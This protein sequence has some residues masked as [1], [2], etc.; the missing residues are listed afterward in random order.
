VTS[1]STTFFLGWIILAI[2]ILAGILVVLNVVGNLLRQVVRKNVLRDDL[3]MIGQIA[4]V[5]RTIR[6]GRA[7]QISCRMGLAD[8]V[9]V[10][11]VSDRMISKGTKVRITAISHGSFRVLPID[12]AKT[13]RSSPVSPQDL[14]KDSPQDEVQAGPQQ[15]KE[16][17]PAS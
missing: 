2:V 13:R 12:R 5:T 17:G 14:E 1:G 6:K 15:Q 8:P 3:D 16:Q 10:D 9:L 11:A 4:E 7:G